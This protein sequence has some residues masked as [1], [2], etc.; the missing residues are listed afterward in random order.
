MSS[1]RKMF[2]LNFGAVQICVFFYII[3]LFR[4]IFPVRSDSS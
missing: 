1:N 2:D 4:Y 3:A